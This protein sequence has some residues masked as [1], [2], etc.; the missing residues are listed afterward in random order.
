M[1]ISEEQV[2]EFI[3]LYKKEYDVELER[4]DALEQVN[5][6]ITLVSRMSPNIQWLEENKEML[7][8]INATNK[9]I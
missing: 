3:T 2:D 9:V 7:Y 1:K 6:L 4:T 5:A 8:N